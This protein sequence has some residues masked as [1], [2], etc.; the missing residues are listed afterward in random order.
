MQTSYID[1][2]HSV[3]AHLWEVKPGEWL[4]TEL[5]TAQRFRGQGHAARMLATVIAD[6]DAEGATLYCAVEP[7]GTKDSLDY[8]VLEAFYLRRGFSEI[9]PGALKREPQLVATLA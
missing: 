8:E 7:D 2:E 6:A 5:Q 4:L 9:E 1:L 3:T